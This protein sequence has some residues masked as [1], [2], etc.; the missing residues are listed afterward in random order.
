MF[1]TKKDEKLEE[2]RIKALEV[3]NQNSP[4]FNH[5]VKNLKWKEKK[6]KDK[7]NLRTLGKKN[8]NTIYLNID[9]TANPDDPKTIDIVLHE[10]SH[11]ISTDIHGLSSNAHDDNFFEIYEKLTGKPQRQRFKDGV[12][13][14]I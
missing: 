1:G 2:L 10:L 5:Y 6:F 7:G 9:Y 11:S 13:V 12:K 3:V 8:G 4:E 14:S